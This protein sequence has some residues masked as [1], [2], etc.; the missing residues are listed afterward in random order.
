MNNEKLL[1]ELLIYF[2]PIA[3][4]NLCLDQYCN[5]PASLGA[6]ILINRELNPLTPSC[7]F[8]I[9]IIGVADCCDN[10]NAD[11]YRSANKV[12][13]ELYR[14]SRISSNIHIA[15]LGNLKTGNSFSDSMLAL[16]QACTLLLQLKANVIIL[17]GSQLYTVP[18]FR[19]F[20]EVESDI[21]MVVVD[22]KIDYHPK[23]VVIDASNFLK[24]LFE[25]EI[26][27]AYN[28]TNL[29]YQTFFVDQKQIAKLTE[30]YFEHYRLG[31]VK[32]E[33]EDVEAVLR[34]ADLV[35]F[36]ISAIRLADAPAQIDGSP[37]GIDA[38]EACV[39]SRYAGISDRNRTFG[40]FGYL[41]EFDVR[42]QTAKLISQIVWYYFD[43][44]YAR[45]H[46]FPAVSIADY[47]KYSVT[48]DEIEF[49]IV[50]YKSNKSER[51]WL[52]IGNLR[53]DESV[54]NVIVACSEKDYKKACSNE[55]P[56]RWW[57][58]F[59]KLR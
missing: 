43:G 47:T 13:E 30:H 10:D 38:E 53:N 51:W 31:H 40:I 36:D 50:F 7:K 22:S 37:N 11:Y 41:P 14:L 32:S 44:F 46:D 48:I 26:S 55:I 56:E 45:K 16:Q 3:S 17:G 27:S 57:T 28:I 49:P 21:N 29:G 58:N 18:N 24:E 2:Q 20:K 25:K 34:D 15:D 9:A 4:S 59:K 54:D 19:A 1:S 39:L 23:E 5:E 12:R 6:N 35:S 52:E 42:N 8:E 33:Y